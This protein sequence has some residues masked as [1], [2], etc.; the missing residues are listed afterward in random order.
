MERLIMGFLA[1]LFLASIPLAAGNSPGSVRVFPDRKADAYSL[2]LG[3]H[4]ISTN[5]SIDDINRMRRAASGDF[6]WFRRDSRSYRIED[7]TVLQ[8]AKN[9]FAPLR[10]LDPEK[11]VLH[12]RE[13]AL[14]RK[15]DAIDRGEEELDRLKDDGSDEDD[16]EIERR[17][18]ELES[19]RRQIEEEQREVEAFERAFEAKEEA[20]EKK[21]EE[22]L[23]KLIDQALASGLAQ[24]IKPSS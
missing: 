23:W 20:L 10:A 2:A 1:A 13:R 7:K 22:Q 21:A 4:W 9:F 11:A 6:L 15:E 14:E 17:Q 3:D 8:Q 18:R 12:R 19:R 16:E 24:P 5:I